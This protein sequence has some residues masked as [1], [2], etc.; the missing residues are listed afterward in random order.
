[1]REDLERART[2][3]PDAFGRLAA[4]KVERLLVPRLI[5]GDRDLAD[6]AV[7]ETLVRCWRYLP[8]LRDADRFEAWLDRI[9]MR[10]SPTS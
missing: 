6:D 5:L 7:Q 9:L 4:G 8:T 2:G 3:D 10:L 1:M